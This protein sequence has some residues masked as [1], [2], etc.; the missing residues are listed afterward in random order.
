MPQRGRHWGEKPDPPL[1]TPPAR[2]KARRV[3]PLMSAATRRSLGGD[4][5]QPQP[6]SGSPGTTGWPADGWGKWISWIRRPVPFGQPS[7]GKACD[8]SPTHRL[9]RPPAANLDTGATDPC[10]TQRRVRLEPQFSGEGT[11]P[12]DG[13]GDPTLFAPWRLIFDALQGF[14]RLAA[15]PRT[16][17]G[18]RKC[19]APLAPAGRT[20]KPGE[21]QNLAR[22]NLC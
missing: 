1:G 4:G 17:G 11:W 13:T 22:M 14:G 8:L 19:R 20:G 10:A 21:G 18:P 15:Q 9:D 2:T 12:V 3:L 7:K 16:P 5:P 6:P